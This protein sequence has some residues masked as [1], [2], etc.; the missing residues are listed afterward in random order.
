MRSAVAVHLNGLGLAL[1]SARYASIANSS[2][3]TLRN[4]PRRIRFSVT[5]A[6]SR[7]TWLSHDPLVGAGLP[8]YK[9]VTA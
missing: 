3:F 6:K 8:H 7:S 9:P 5:P 1:C 4:T 2:A